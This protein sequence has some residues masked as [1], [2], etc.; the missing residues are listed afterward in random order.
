[1]FWDQ[2]TL[3]SLIVLAAYYQ[4]IEKIF[5][6][7]KNL[8]YI[9]ALKMMLRGSVCFIECIGTELSRIIFLGGHIFQLPYLYAYQKAELHFLSCSIRN[10][11]NM[12]FFS[13]QR[14]NLRKKYSNL[15]Y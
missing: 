1:M 5:S 7:P 13:V 2:Y 12:L 11:I 9:K 15:Q 14:Q 8:N 6:N 4:S 3:S 10:D